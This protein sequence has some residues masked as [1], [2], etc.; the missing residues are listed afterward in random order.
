RNKD[1]G[2]PKERLSEIAAQPSVERLIDSRNCFVRVKTLIGPMPFNIRAC[3][4]DEM[5][6][7]MDRTAARLKEGRLPEAGTNEVAL[8]ENLM[9]ANDWDLGR[10]FGVDVD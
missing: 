4:R 3:R 6:L 10:E 8:H 5:T 1:S 9:R 7:L 2:L